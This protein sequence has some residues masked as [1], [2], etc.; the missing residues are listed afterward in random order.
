MTVEVRKK[1]VGGKTYHLYHYDN[2]TKFHCSMCGKDKRSKTAVVREEDNHIFC[3][4]CYRKMAGQ[5]K[6]EKRIKRVGEIVQQCD[7]TPREVYKCIP[8]LGKRVAQS[9][10][11]FLCN[12]ELSEKLIKVEM[13]NG[14]DVIV[15]DIPSLYCSHCGVGVGTVDMFAAAKRKYPGYYMDYFTIGRKLAEVFTLE[16]LWGKINAGD[17]KAMTKDKS[18]QMLN[19]HVGAPQKVE[20]KKYTIT[21]E[22]L[23]ELEKE[24]ETLKLVKRKEVARKIREASE[25]GNTEYKKAKEEQHKIEQRISKIENILNN[26]E[27]IADEVPLTTIVLG[28][29]VL[30]YDKEYEEQIRYT[31]V[32]TTQVNSLANKISD[33][34]P[35][36]KAL[37]GKKKGDVVKV[38]TSGAEYEILDIEGILDEYRQ[39]A[40]L[41]QKKGDGATVKV[42]RGTTEIKDVS[43]RHFITRVNVFKCTNKNHKLIDIRCRIKVMSRNGSVNSYVV[44]GAYCQDCDKYFLLETEYKKLKQIGVLMCRV[45]EQDFWTQGGKQKGNFNLNQE[46]VLHMMGYNVNAQ[47]NLTEIQRR[48]IL[49]LIVDEGILSVAQIRSHIQWLIERNINN[50]SFREARHK[51]KIDCDYIAQYGASKRMLVDVDG[52]TVK[53]YHKR[54]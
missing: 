15:G 23:C 30:L 38:I 45:V 34:S 4:E 31:I 10:R 20:K 18:K 52:I 26:T 36:G 44:P 27:V 11:C 33:E 42:E 29:I 47:E 46:S 5:D 41:A 17:V 22:R 48:K 54:N 50:P 13:T 28:S 1:N 35:L 53:H 3:T 2:M 39:M 14:K 12:S 19:Q 51:W 24:F 37:L 21:Y 8:R 16:A 9:G 40:L 25:K 32:D 49:E 6:K 7:C 43:P